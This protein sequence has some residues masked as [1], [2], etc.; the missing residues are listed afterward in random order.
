MP[1]TI[2]AAML[3]LFAFCAVIDPA[4]ALFCKTQQES[5]LAA[6]K[7]AC[8]QPAFALAQKNS[9]TPGRDVAESI[10]ATLR[11]GGFDGKVEVYYYEAPAALTGPA[12]RLY[13]VGVQV[14]EDY[15]TIVSRGMGIE[16]L[17]VASHTVFSAVPYSEERAWRPART[18]SGVY[19]QASPEAGLAW[20]EKTGV[21]DF[22]DEVA[23]EAA[24]QLEK[25][26]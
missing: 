4:C 14:S 26:K 5:A 19:A 6:A 22:P 20:T 21:E 17:P 25:I 24:S 2:A 9:E 3:L 13:A 7:E 12:K 18:Y 10:V 8:M 23:A 16:T 1:A 11:E 15:E